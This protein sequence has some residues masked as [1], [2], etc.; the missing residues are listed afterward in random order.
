MSLFSE[1]IEVEI[2]EEHGRLRLLRVL[3]E[4]VFEYGGAKNG[5]AA[6]RDPM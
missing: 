1:G 2:E 5:L 4:H 3:V 6:A